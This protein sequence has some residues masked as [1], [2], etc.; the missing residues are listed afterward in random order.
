MLAALLN[1]TRGE[2]VIVT[3][4]SLAF[5]LR[6]HSIPGSNCFCDVTC[7]L[8]EPIEPCSYC[9]KLMHCCREATPK[10]MLMIDSV[11]KYAA[12]RK[13]VVIFVDR[14]DDIDAAEVRWAW[15][16]Q[17]SFTCCITSAQLVY[18]NNWNCY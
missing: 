2:T 9:L 7:K 17:R 5:Q 18:Q 12:Q 13:P 14:R 10:G 6:T 11:K 1:Q 8:Q 16:G 15:M 4:K 3:S